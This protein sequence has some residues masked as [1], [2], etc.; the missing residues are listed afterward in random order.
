MDTITKPEATA[1]TLKAF[2][3]EAGKAG[4]HEA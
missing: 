3:V 2:A 1:R 4:A